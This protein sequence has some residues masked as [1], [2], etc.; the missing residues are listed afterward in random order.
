M[1]QP[2]DMD[3]VLRVIATH[4]YEQIPREEDPIHE[5]LRQIHRELHSKLDHNDD[6][7][8]L[9]DLYDELNFERYRIAEKRFAQGFI[10]GIRF[11]HS[12]TTGFNL[13]KSMD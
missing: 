3:D 10:E 12:L 13:H 4:R 6:Q 5:Q 9:L 7:M 2:L 8:K 1:L 11:L